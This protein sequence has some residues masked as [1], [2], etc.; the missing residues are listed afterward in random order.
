MNREQLL[1][2]TLSRIEILRAES[3][4]AN[5]KVLNTPFNDP[6]KDLYKD[7]WKQIHNEFNSLLSLVMPLENSIQCLQNGGDLTTLTDKLGKVHESIPDFRRIETLNIAF[8]EDT[9]LE[10]PRPKYIPVVDE[11][12]L[13][14]KGYVF[15]SIRIE[16]D[17]Y[18]LATKTF[19]WN[20]ENAFVIVTLDQL[21]LILDYYIK[22]AKAINEVEAEKRSSANEAYWDRLSEDRKSSFLNQK[23]LYFSLPVKIKKTITQSDYESLDWI[24]KEK[25]YKFYK[26]YGA[27]RLVSK[28]EDKQMWVSF[29]DMYQQFVNPD[30]HPVNSKGE[31]QVGKRAGLGLYGNKE[32]FTYWYWF[33]DMLDFKIKDIKAQR[34][35]LA[36]SYQQAIETSFGA[37]NTNDTLK[38]EF[39][40]LVKRQNGDP[41]N[42]V[43]IEQ[44]KDVWSMVQQTFGNLKV[45]SDKHNI[46]VSHSG[47][48]LIF[49]TKAIGV[50]IK[51]MGTIG[52]SNKYGD[53]QFKS[54]LAHEIAHFIDNFIGEI[55]G[56]RWAS[57]DYESLAGQIAFTFRNNMNKPKAQQTD[58]INSTKECFARAFQQYFGYIN[59]GD[60]ASIAHSYVDLGTIQKIYNSDNFLNKGDFT[61]KVLPLIE[62]FLEENKDVFSFG[63]D[64]DH[65]NKIVPVGTEST[66]TEPSETSIDTEKKEIQDAIDGLTILLG[67]SDESESQ[68]I[69]DTID[70]LKF[71][72][73]I[74]QV[75]T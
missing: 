62:Q 23:G 48:K 63:T 14:Y 16:K 24:E 53:L 60:E 66:G 64:V 4:L 25:L 72:L 15:D 18:I 61:Q 38:N 22:K 34:D 12:S 30:A 44:I 46:K 21:I 67:V 43:E 33:R 19:K 49:A 47:N 58:Y 36:E 70:G 35:D 45:N 3:K 5:E 50:Y 31:L 39:G 54:T 27:K 41:I 52:I 8:D 29:H 1:K 20:E 65:S 37:S 28:L 71:L 55:N 10:S 17:T 11:K 6:N 75:S 51:E 7:E 42:P 56:K 57:D 13:E 40:I 59:F 2:D 69:Q 9:I 32:I 73:Q 74:G 68:E 26:R